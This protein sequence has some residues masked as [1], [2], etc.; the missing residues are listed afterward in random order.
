MKKRH[1]VFHKL[2]TQPFQVM[3]I[4]IQYF[5]MYLRLHQNQ[6][7]GCTSHKYPH[8]CSGQQGPSLRL[9]HLPPYTWSGYTALKLDMAVWLVLTNEV[10]VNI[11]HF[12]REAFKSFCRICYIPCPRPWLL[13]AFQMAEP[14]SLGGRGGQSS[15]ES[16]ARPTELPA[17]GNKP[18]IF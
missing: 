5:L 12:W 18:L 15:R 11:H 4:S 2:L 8:P 14:I 1:P 9:V 10:R 17:R 3:F 13:A 16:P 6:S 7:V